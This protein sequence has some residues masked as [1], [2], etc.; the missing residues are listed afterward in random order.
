VSGASESASPSESANPLARGGTT[1]VLD[2]NPKSIRKSW[3]IVLGTF[4]GEGAAVLAA[5]FMEQAKQ[6]G[7]DGS[8]METKDAGYAVLLGQLAD[9][10]ASESKALL[11]KIRATRHGTDLPYSSAILAPPAVF[12]E[13]G[14]RPEWD[15]RNVRRAVVT[16]GNVYTLQVA[17][18]GKPDRSRAAPDEIAQFRDAAEKAV[19][20][21]RSSGDEAYYFHGPER[22]T[23]T[24][25][26]FSTTNTSDPRIAEL[27]RKYPHNLVNGAAARVT[28]VG[29]TGSNNSAELQPSF[30]V[31]VP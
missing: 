11:A 3:A 23:V 31:S 29:P 8:F 10:G 6:D 20:E 17:I 19:A 4:T 28:S 22:S 30:I 12:G 9:P 14:S 13:A 16:K 18:Y 26:V 1:T 21:L 15:L 25:G 5:R 2:Q 27:R 7:L 24:I